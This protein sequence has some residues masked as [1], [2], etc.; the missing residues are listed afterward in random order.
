MDMQPVTDKL[1]LGSRHQRRA[2]KPRLTVVQRLHG[3]EEMR[4]LR[5]ARLESGHCRGVIRSGM[6]EG[7][8]AHLRRLADKLH[9]AVKLRRHGD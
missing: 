2:D 4:R 5:R 7:Y 1:D 9:R 8:S 6:A 3:V